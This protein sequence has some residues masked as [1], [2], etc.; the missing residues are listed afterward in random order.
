MAW[1]STLVAVVALMLSASAG[2]SGEPL[3]SF[4]ATPG[5][6]PKSVVPSHYAIELTPNLQTLTLAGSETIDVDVREPV[7]R[8]VLNAVDIAIGEAWID[9][10]AQRTDI[11]LEPKAETATLAFSNALT[12]GAHKIRLTFTAKINAFGRGMFYVDYPT[13]AGTTRMLSTQL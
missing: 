2:A 8:V 7:W 12:P 1:K 10:G 5:K 3:F 11:S 6:L 4:D 9:D 13:D